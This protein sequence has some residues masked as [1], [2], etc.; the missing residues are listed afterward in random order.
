MHVYYKVLYNMLKKFTYWISFS[1]MIFFLMWYGFVIIWILP[2]YYKTLRSRVMYEKMLLN[3][4]KVIN[5]KYFYSDDDE[6]Q[7]IIL[8]KTKEKIEINKEEKEKLKN[9]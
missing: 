3:K 9:I 7:K 5:Q 6:K 2:M 8:I 1:K 4:N